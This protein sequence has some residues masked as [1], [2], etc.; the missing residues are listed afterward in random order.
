[1]TLKELL[2]KDIQDIIKSPELSTFL[3]RT[4]SELYLN[5]RPPRF[6]AKSQTKYFNELKINGMEKAKRINV[7]NFT[8]L[9]YIPTIVVDGK[10]V[11]IHQ[12]ISPE[13]LTDAKATELLKSGALKES[14]FKVLPYEKKEVEIIYKEKEDVKQTYTIDEVISILNENDYKKKIALGKALGLVKGNVKETKINQKLND[15]IEQNS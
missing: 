14:D 5:R 9:K 10:M 3:L 2:T 11:T 6:C 13:H 4:Y 12:H 1:M 8:G 7:P 15:Y